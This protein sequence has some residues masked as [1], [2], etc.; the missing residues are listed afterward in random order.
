LV[1]STNKALIQ[2]L[3]NTI[4][5]N[6]QNWLVKLIDA[7]WASRLT[8]ENNTIL[9]TYTLVYGKETRVPIHFEL[10][11]LTYALNT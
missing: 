1:D 6:Q 4:N 5:E 11:A 9:S 2:I 3:K 8:P 10:N 7:L